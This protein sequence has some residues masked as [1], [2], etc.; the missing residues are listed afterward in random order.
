MHR[1]VS[2]KGCDL[3]PGRAEIDDPVLRVQVVD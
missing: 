3:R 1:T 2:R